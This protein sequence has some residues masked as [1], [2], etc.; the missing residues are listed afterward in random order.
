MDSSLLGLF[1]SSRLKLYTA[2]IE[3][4]LFGESIDKATQ[5]FSSQEVSQLMGLASMLSNSDCKNDLKSAYEIIT[6]LLEI[7]V[8]HREEL[9]TAADIIL[10]RLG[11]FPGRALLRNRYSVESNAEVST[12]LKL[13]MIARE[14]EN[15]VEEDCDL[16][17]TD[18]QYDLYEAL[19]EEQSLSVS[20]PT[21]AGKSYVLSLDLIR[22]LRLIEKQCI[23][24][25]VPTRALITEVSSRIRTALYEANLT[26]VIVRTAPF[27]VDLEEIKS[28]AVYVLTQERLMSL[29]NSDEEN[30]KVDALMVDEAHEIQKGKRGI[31]LQNAI[32]NVLSKFS[33]CS[34]LFAS[35]LIKNP[36]YFLSLFNRNESGR[37]FVE[38]L[39]PVSQNIILLSSVHGKPQQVSISQLLEGECINLGIRDV[40]FKFRGPKTKQHALL[41]HAIAKG[42]D[43]TIVFANG[44]AKAEE[45]ASVLSEQ[46]DFNGYDQAV[47]EFIEFLAA[48]VHEE[49][50]LIDCLKKGVAFH[51]GD[52]PSIVRKGVED[53]FKSG[54]INYICCTSTLLQG[55]NLPA[56]NIIIE[57]PH[58]GDNPMK[59]ADFLNL[60][61]RAGRLLEEFH[62]NIWCVRP[63]EWAE[64]S[65]KGERLSEITSAMSEVMNDGGLD[66]QHLL[67]SESLEDNKRDNAEA[68]FARLYSDYLLNDEDITKNKYM[69]DDNA[70]VLAETLSLCDEIQIEVP[71]EILKAH[72]ALRPD[73]IQAVLNHLSCQTSLDGLIPMSPRL[74]GSKAI[75]EQIIHII[76]ECFEWSINEKYMPLLSYI[77]YNWMWEKSI[78]AILRDRI[79]YVRKDNPKASV[80]APIRQALKTIESD[81]RFKLVK[82]FAVYSDV[83]K[84]VLASRGEAE[85]IDS[86]E[87]L[88][89]YFEFGSCDKVAL[90]LMA[91]GLSRFSALNLAK[92]YGAL[93]EEDVEPE[94][95]IEDLRNVD[96]DKSKMPRLCIKEVKDLI[97]YQ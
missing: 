65:Y 72:R 61:G 43:S 2:S 21:S 29:I 32:D 53:L 54:S 91:L 4:Q 49:Y 45:I 70:E 26:G 19:K 57:D 60:A 55:V 5:Q 13:E 44:P 77:A 66:I 80:S 92:E 40:D 96:L 63:S 15:T 79:V 9:F 27:P 16:S 33:G 11:N 71:S 95:Y 97:I 62:G 34:V 23:V 51:Y 94:Q 7:S 50:P 42:K 56:K 58:N 84:Y 24:Y 35:P 82:Y 81:V 73:H 10:S 59:R 20:A 25:V 12:W 75:M 83:L 64:E 93:F 52:M 85:L 74:K 18:F 39:S 87:P 1:E 6:R 86:V 36:A 67:N 28:G 90:N 48:E 3:S 89:I 68:A 22:R 78:S 8:E 31:V 30:F 47:I 46:I 38:E 41:A 37:Y 14:A 88:H 17:L 69:T 76:S